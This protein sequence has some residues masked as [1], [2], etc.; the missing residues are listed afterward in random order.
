[1]NVQPGNLAKVVAPYEASGRGALV[2][3]V[4]RAQWPSEILGTSIYAV[5]LNQ[6]VWVVQGFVRDE[7]G[8]MQGPLLCIFDHCLQRVDEGDQVV[9]QTSFVESV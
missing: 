4:R 2:N 3:V 9:E 7:Q 8:H 5:S 1:M 6:L